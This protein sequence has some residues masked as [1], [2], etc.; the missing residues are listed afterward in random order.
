MSAKDDAVDTSLLSRTDSPFSTNGVSAKG[1]VARIAPVERVAPGKFPPKPD[2]SSLS[3]HDLLDAREQYHVYLSNLENVVAT[4]IGRY[5]IHEKDW[6]AKHP[7]D[8]P[9]PD[10]SPHV[11]LPRSIAN[12]SCGPGPGRQFWCSSKAGAHSK[13]SVATRYPARSI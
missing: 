7:P 10:D 1:R 2:Y 3:V 12:S 9:R 4:A 6:F 8:Q 11:S 13:S 5:R